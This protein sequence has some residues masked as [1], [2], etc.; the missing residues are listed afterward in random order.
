MLKNSKGRTIYKG[1]RGGYYVLD[2]LRKIYKFKSAPDAPA[3][4]RATKPLP[5]TKTNVKGRTIYKGP[6]GGYYVLE[7]LRKIYK[8]KVASQTTHAVKTPVKQRLLKLASN[9][10]KRRI[11]PNT[12]GFSTKDHQL[13]FT[14]FN[15]EN[16]TINPK[17][18]S[19]YTVNITVP[20]GTSQLNNFI[21]N[22]TVLGVTEDT[23]PLQSWMDAQNR[24][25]KS[26]NE[27]DLYTAMSYT[28]RSH[29]WIGPW[30]RG[31]KTVK[32]T[33]PRGFTK[34]LWH[35]CLKLGDKQNYDSFTVDKKMIP[36]AM[37]LY[38]KDLR[39]IIRNA[40]PLPR[41]MHVYRGT[42]SDVFRGKTGATHALGEF[43]SAAYV[44]QRVYAGHGY[45][46]I[47]LLK[48][49]RVLLLQGLNHWNNAGE[50]EI[51]LN[52]GSKYIIRK[53]ELKRLA[54]NTPRL[55]NFY[56]AQKKPVT[57]ITVYSS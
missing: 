18:T 51:L 52:R 32:F 24:Y 56:Y 34:P 22:G 20:S 27:Y 43:A 53:R 2:G 23:L 6:R 9:V 33:R 29:E 36:K 45:T 15:T 46:R 25:L 8:F 16:P 28:V 40:P 19:E 55:A 31:S 26:L 10:K 4:P 37:E 30:M 54:F 47:K 57:D 44:P 13:K 12:T 7:G 48:G 3:L 5:V 49:T 14:S 11:R 1:P 50:F 17:L 39:R 21:K 42:Y 35:Q 41:T 38:I